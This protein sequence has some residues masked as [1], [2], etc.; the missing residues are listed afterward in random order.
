MNLSTV[1][2]SGF[3]HPLGR[4]TTTIRAESFPDGQLR[5]GNYWAISWLISLD[6]SGLA[7]RNQLHCDRHCLVGGTLVP[8]QVYAPAAYVGEAVACV[9]N[10]GSAGGVG[11]L[12]YGNRA[13][14]DRDQAGTRMRVPPGVSPDWER[15]LDDIDVRIS[16][17]LQLE[18][19]PYKLNSLHIK[20]SKPD[21]KWPGVGVRNVV[22]TPHEG[23]ARAG[24]TTMSDSAMRSGRINIFLN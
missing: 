4:F 3:L 18:V 6:P 2:P 23:V 19:P 17:H 16:L 20:S 24:A 22:V 21:E 1:R 13:R 5:T 11:G 15:V 14:R 7:R 9:I 10:V 8:Q 12:V